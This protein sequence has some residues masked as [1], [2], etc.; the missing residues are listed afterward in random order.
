LADPQHSSVRNRLLAALPPGDFAT[1]H[2]RLE[3]VP[4]QLRDVLVVPG[5]PIEH[6]YFP[7]SGFVSAVA[8]SGGER[9]E[10]GLIGRE[11]FVGVPVVLGRNSSPQEYLVQGTGEA[12]RM[13]SDDLRDAV[14]QSRALFD[15]LLGFVHVMMVQTAQTAFANGTHTIEARL[16]RWLLMCQ[17][18]TEGDEVQLTHDFMSMMLGVRRQGVTTATHV[19]EAS[20]LIKARRGRITIVDRDRLQELAAESYGVPETEYARFMEDVSAR[21]S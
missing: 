11:G 21:G 5:E 4:L 15:L 17:D 8:T 6:V 9:I 7:Q 16:A 10:V 19:L 1:L 20:G 2:G 12:L 18:R 14:R 13:G 3:P